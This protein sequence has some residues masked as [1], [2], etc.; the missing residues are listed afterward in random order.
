MRVNIVVCRQLQ[1]L[2][3]NCLAFLTDCGR[4]EALAVPRGLGP[5]VKIAAFQFANC[6]CTLPLLTLFTASC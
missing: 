1:P 6:E 4:R 2:T 5:H 3:G